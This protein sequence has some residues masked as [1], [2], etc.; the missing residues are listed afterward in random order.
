VQLVLSVISDHRLELPRRKSTEKHFA[1]A[2]HCNG[3]PKQRAMTMTF[4]QIGYFLALAAEGTFARAARRCGISQPSLT[5]AIKSLESALGACLF[6]RT[7]TGSELTDFGRQMYPLLARLH[8]DKLRA[9]RLA[10]TFDGSA[11]RMPSVWPRLAASKRRPMQG[12]GIRKPHR[13]TITVALTALL[14]C[15]VIATASPVQAKD[16]DA[17]AAMPGNTHWSQPADQSTNQ[18]HLVLP[19]ARR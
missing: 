19:P 18:A 4:E 1:N 8:Y 3:R 9:L 6:E 16:N 5:N 2:G 7:P 10:R 17:E 12:R 13:R 14:A 11:N 15:M